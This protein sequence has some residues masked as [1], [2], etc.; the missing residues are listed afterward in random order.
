MESTLKTKTGNTLKSRYA[1]KKTTMHNISEDDRKMLE[2]NI[3]TLYVY[4]DLFMDTMSE[5]EL[6]AWQEI[7]EKLDPEYTENN[8][9]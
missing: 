2:N 3:D 5:D 6:Q 7:L 4:L 9:Q 1:C 8:N